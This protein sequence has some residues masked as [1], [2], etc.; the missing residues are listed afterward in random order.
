MESQDLCARWGGSNSGA[1]QRIPS[2][3]FQEDEYFL[4]GALVGGV[5]RRLE[6][7]THIID[8]FVFICT[9]PSTHAVGQY[10]SSE[11]NV[12]PDDI[13]EYGINFLLGH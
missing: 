1:H 7:A 6:H 4:Y 12:I 8:T 10:P 5:E 2:L 3:A 9:E 11:L 13:A